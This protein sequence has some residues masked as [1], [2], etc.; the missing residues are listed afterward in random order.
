[1]MYVDP[2]V[3][4]LCPACGN[5]Y[6]GSSIASYTVFHVF[7]FSDGSSRSE[8]PSKLWLTRCPRCRHFF[9]KE[10]LFEFPMTSR[11][12]EFIRYDRQ[13]EYDNKQARTK[14]NN[15]ENQKLYGSVDYT[16]RENENVIDF[17]EQA[18]E[19]GL[20]FPV[21]VSDSRKEEL[22]IALHR[23]LWWEYNQNRDKIANEDYNALC[24]K[25]IKMLISTK[26]I[27]REKELMLAELYRNIGNF[28]E[29]FKQ[30]E[31][32]FVNPSIQVYVDCI[33]KQ[34]EQKNNRTV[35]VEES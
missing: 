4:Y 9:A 10:H 34:I 21:N 28:E 25:L 16:L 23:T 24:E 31:E 19:V 14:I 12:A 15:R 8:I 29:S 35:I 30:L 18:I 6:F 5:P 20:Y 26:S 22:R 2:I 1:M 27:I 7:K 3:N 33:K 32:L 13:R 17:L 11:V